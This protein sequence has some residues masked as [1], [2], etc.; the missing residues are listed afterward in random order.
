M[1]VFVDFDS[2][3]WSGGQDPLA[4]GAAAATG[5]AP[6]MKDALPVYRFGSISDEN[7]PS[8]LPSSSRPGSSES[9]FNRDVQ[10]HEHADKLLLL[11]DGHPQSQS[12]SQSEE[13]DLN[14]DHKLATILNCYPAVIQIARGVD[15]NTL[16]ALSATCRRLYAAL[17]PVRNLLVKETLCCENEILAADASQ[18]DADPDVIRR[19]RR[20]SRDN[21]SRGR[22]V[23]DLVKE[24][25]K[26]HQ[27]VCRNCIGKPFTSAKP[28]TRRLCRKCLSAPITAHAQSIINPY[29]NFIPL[30]SYQQSL[31]SNWAF[32]RC[33]EETWLCIPCTRAQHNEDSLYRA[34]WT[35]RSKYS[36]L[37]APGTWA[38]IGQGCEGVKCGR[39][40]GCFAA[41]HIEVEI[42][43]NHNDSQADASSASLRGAEDIDHLSRSSPGY[44]RQEIVGVG[45]L[46]KNKVRKRIAVGAVVE[47]YPEER[48][49]G[50]Y[51]VLESTGEVRS[52]CGW[53]SKVISSK[54]ER[55]ALEHEAVVEQ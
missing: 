45:G 24:C 37:F 20:L 35:W 27:M 32:C 25:T 9:Y 36:S 40:A 42:E 52:W 19:S 7:P 18:E 43:S 28:R 2:D 6:A 48:E 11:H 4:P 41:Q 31:K 15:S 44:F 30:I 51:L 47:E 17:L 55:A 13:P 46:V 33:E 5:T 53:C 14:V 1:V 23:R 29:Q 10:K 39:G 22:C 50:T 49:T 21:T 3:Q 26:C 38:G 8:E 16:H 54:A 34:G 12:K